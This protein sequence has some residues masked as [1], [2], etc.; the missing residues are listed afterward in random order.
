MPNETGIVYKYF[1]LI[2][3][4]IRVKVLGQ[5]VSLSVLQKGVGEPPSRREYRRLVVENCVI[6]VEEEVLPKVHSIYPEDTIAA[7]DLLYQI[8]VDVNPNLDIHSVAL[9]AGGAQEE[10]ENE[11]MQSFKERARLLKDAVLK[12]LIGQDEAVHQIC[13]SVRKSASGIG[14]PQRPV[15]SYLL[16][17]RTGTGKTEL[18]KSLARHLYESNNLVRIDCSEFALPHETAKLIG[19]PPGYVGHNDG[20]TLTEALMRDPHAVV[21]FDEI[22]KGHEKLHNMLL[23]ILDD[24]RLTDSKGN[25]VSFTKALVLMTSNVGT[26]DYAEATNRLGFGRDGGLEICDFDAITS[27]ALRRN[28]K[29]E[30]MNRLDGVLTF[31]SLTPENCTTIAGLL[32]QKLQQRM[33]NAGIRLKWS[34]R[35]AE[36]VAEAGYCE[37]YGAREVRRALARLVE[38]PLSNAIMDGEFAPGQKVTAGWRGGRVTFRG[39]AA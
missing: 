22:E 28:F 34:K 5:D 31:R 6:A 17:G 16:V 11:A 9:P 20:G 19:A 15:G 37:E 29:P 3:G 4:F 30:L 39:D 27:V 1:D 35:L 13:R 18:A 24:G 2:D 25:T 26:A 10:S 12:E 32:L 7:E 8:C 38:E 36:A 14:D 23:Q 21:L 33:D